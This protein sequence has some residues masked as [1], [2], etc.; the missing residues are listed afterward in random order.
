MNGKP[1]FNLLIRF[2]NH[3]IILYQRFK[4]NITKKIHLLRREQHQ[5]N[6]K[7]IKKLLL[8]KEKKVKVFSDFF[9]SILF[10]I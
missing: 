2:S 10:I 1:F 5:L 8:M 7:K 3:L 6:N 9:I 4:N